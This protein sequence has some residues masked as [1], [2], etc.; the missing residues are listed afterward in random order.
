MAQMAV[1]LVVQLSLLWLSWYLVRR[2]QPEADVGYLLGVASA[3]LL[4][5]TKV[6]PSAA[7]IEDFAQTYAPYIDQEAQNR[8]AAR[9]TAATA[10]REDVRTF[11]VRNLADV[12]EINRIVDAYGRILEHPKGAYAECM[13]KPSSSLPMPKATI[14]NALDALLDYAHG[15]TDTEL[16]NPSIRSQDYIST[17][18]AC[19]ISLDFFVDI[20]PKELP[21]DMQGNALIGGRLADRVREANV[22]PRSMEMLSPSEFARRTQGTPSVDLDLRLYSGQFY[23]CGCG[24]VH[25]FEEHVTTVLRQL[26]GMRVAIEC[27]TG[28]FVTCV[29]VD[30]A[31]KSGGFTARFAMARG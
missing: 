26:P 22:M 25:V 6:F 15:K 13:Y 27:P 16:L 19:R 14:E 30:G 17:L 28:R 10:R 24:D 31:T 20:D 7:N 3:V 1:I 12:E 4:G 9:R 21:T 5:I 11:D 29:R 8:D 2:W 23:E 18:R